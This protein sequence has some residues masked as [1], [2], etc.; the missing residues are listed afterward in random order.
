[1]RA[2][3]SQQKRKII[4]LAVI[5]LLSPV[6]VILADIYAV[7]DNLISDFI[8]DKTRIF[9]IVLFAATHLSLGIISISLMPIKP[10]TKLVLIPFY[11]ILMIPVTMA[12]GFWLGCIVGLAHGCVSP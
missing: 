12:L 11:I 5:A 4:L 1:M 8:I 3:L 10:F 6:L 7:P 9:K 2:G